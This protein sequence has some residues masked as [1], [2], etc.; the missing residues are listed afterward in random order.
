MASISHN[1]TFVGTLQS[2][3]RGIPIEVKNVAE[4]ERERF[5]CQCFWKSSENKLVLHSYVF[6]T[7]SSGQRNVLLLSTVQLILGVTIDDGK[8]KPAICKLYDFTKAGTDAMEQRISAYTCK[9]KSNPWNLTAFCYILN[10]HRINATTVIA[11]SKKIDLCKQYLYDFGM[12]L[13]FLF[14]RPTIQR[15]P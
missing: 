11:F 15:R 6:P 8:K 12:N 2:N 10:V 5:F 1:I 7:K 9:A 13:A 14:I 3:R 4:R